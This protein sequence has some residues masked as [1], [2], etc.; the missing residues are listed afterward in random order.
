LRVELTNAPEIS[1]GQQSRPAL[2]A[3]ASRSGNSLLITIVNQ[4][5]DA[6]TEVRIGLHG[7]RAAEATAVN[8]TGQGVRDENTVEHPNSITPQSWKVEIA[9]AGLI[10]RVPARSVQ[11][12]RVKIG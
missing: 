6:N 11:A 9:G 3:S 8:L 7:V 5:P 12:I 4:R 1:N 2:N 10:A